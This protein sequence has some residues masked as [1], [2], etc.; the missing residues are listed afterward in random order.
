MKSPFP[1]W[2]GQVWVGHINFAG[3]DEGQLFAAYSEFKLK[4]KMLEVMVEE[5]PETFPDGDDT[6]YKVT[7]ENI[8]DFL[9]A[10]CDSGNLGYEIDMFYIF[11]EEY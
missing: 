11:D 5:E 8:D 10:G 6:F 7:P 2:N 4:L 9:W 1:D 3:S